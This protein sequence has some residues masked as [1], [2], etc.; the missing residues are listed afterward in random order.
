MKIDLSWDDVAEIYPYLHTVDSIPAESSIVIETVAGAKY[1]IDTY[2]FIESRET[3][4]R[5]LSAAM[6]S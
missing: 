2:H 3:I 5:N 1:R 4:S 6:D